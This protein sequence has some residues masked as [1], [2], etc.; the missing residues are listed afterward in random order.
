MTAAPVPA[1]SDMAAAE[2]AALVSARICHD[3]VSPL[4]AIGNGLELL[5]LCGTPTGPELSLMSQSVAA[6]TAR[7]RLFR[8]AFGADQPGARMARAE[9]TAILSGLAPGA[10]ALVVWPA[11][12]L[13]RNEVRLGFLLLM[14]LE[15]TL[16]YGGGITFRREGTTWAIKAEA[17]RMAI[18]YVLWA[19]ARGR[20]AP[21]A[22]GPRHVHFALMPGALA[23]VGRKLSLHPGDGVLEVRA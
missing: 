3:L 21:D 23:A 4:G 22:I 20:A 1:A 10:R 14:C 18:D 13:P 15:T 6:A 7:M 2:L 5:H 11:E 19:V 12:D 16:P 8:V 17:G 9:V